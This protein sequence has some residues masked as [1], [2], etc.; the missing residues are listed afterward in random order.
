MRLFRGLKLD[1]VFV[2]DIEPIPCVGCHND[3]KKML[4][5]LWERKCHALRREKGWIS[6]Y[7]HGAPLPDTL[8][9][10]LFEQGGIYAESTEE[11]VPRRA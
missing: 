4:K 11:T 1:E 7:D 10:A 2:P 8:H 6:H 5:E 3:L 9:A